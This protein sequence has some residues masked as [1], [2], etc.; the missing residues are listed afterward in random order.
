[1]VSGYGSNR[2]QGE[3]TVDRPGKDVVL[4][5]SSYDK[6]LWTVSNNAANS[7]TVIVSGYDEPS[8][9]AVGTMNAYKVKPGQ[10]GYVQSITD[11]SFS[12]AMGAINK[13]INIRKLSSFTH[14]PLGQGTIDKVV[15]DKVYDDER[16]DMDWPYPE[17][18]P[19]ATFVLDTPNGPRKWTP[20]GPKG[21]KDLAASFPVY[22]GSELEAVA[23]DGTTLTIKENGT[24][25][26]YP[27]PNNFPSFSWAKASG[28]NT[29]DDILC[30]ASFGGEGFF[31]RFDLK[32]KT[33]LDAKS[34]NNEDVGQLIYDKWD[35]V[36]YGLGE[37]QHDFILVIDKAGNINNKI[38]LNEL[39]GASRLAPKIGSGA[40][41]YLI[42]GKN[43][44]FLV[45]INMVLVGHS[46]QGM[47]GAV[48]TVDKK[49]G[50]AR[51]TYRAQVDRQ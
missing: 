43:H 28:L 51:L 34:M 41:T 38:A 11:S 40:S 5:L 50:K 14:V 7:L 19:D 3:I 23:A 49:T 22:P 24:T 30:I 20:Q 12:Q 15:I 39:F 32:S 1:M 29:D 45:N 46:L 47:V 17:P 25:T 37:M 44:L 21:H 13:Q 6:T 8:V 2:G 4:I 18:G 48:W 33:W 35:K 9:E 16:L 36:F 27:L 10:F 42:P 26:S 31:Y